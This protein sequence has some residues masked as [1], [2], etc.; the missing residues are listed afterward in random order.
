MIVQ[1]HEVIIWIGDVLLDDSVVSVDF[2]EP[3]KGEYVDAEHG[4]GE[5]EELSSDMSLLTTHGVE[6]LLDK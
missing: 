4:G 3:V 1:L 2:C 5:N 6:D